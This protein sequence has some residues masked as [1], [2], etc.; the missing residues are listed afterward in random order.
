[1]FFLPNPVGLLSRASCLQ[2]NINIP[3][4]FIPPPRTSTNMRFDFRFLVSIC[5]LAPLAAANAFADE[6]P[7]AA[8]TFDSA[9]ERS[10]FELHG[11]VQFDVAGPRPTEFPDF[12]AKN[13]AVRLDGKGTYLAIADEGAHSR[14]DFANGDAIT[15]EAW[16]LCDAVK[17]TA[18]RY[19]V[20]KGRT[21]SAGF[22]RDNQNW[23]LR[24]VGH[25]EFA[26]ISF[27][28]ANPPGPGTAHWHRWDSKAEFSVMNGW[29]HVAVSYQFGEPESIRGWID[30]VPTDGIWSIGGATSEPPV[31]DDDA[32]WIGS[33]L[34][35]NPGSCFRGALDDIQIHRRA[36][37]DKQVAARFNRVGGPRIVVAMEP[38]MP[39]VGDIP[40]GKVMVTMAESLAAHDRWPNQHEGW[41]EETVSWLGD[42]FLLP[43]IPLR[44]DD[45]GIRTGWKSPVL[46][47]MSADVDLAAGEHQL[48]LRARA[49]G[50]LWIDGKLIASTEP[51]TKDPP[52]GEER[53]LPLP[54]PLQ[55]GMRLPSYRQQEVTGEV[56]VK[57]GAKQLSR[58]VLELVVG[59]KSLR[60][61][62]GEVSI[63]ILST[64]AKPPADSTTWAL[65]TP[66][67]ADRV[68]FTDAAIKPKLNAIEDAIA[69]LDDHTR[70][71]AASS[72]DEFW[73][74]R[75]EYAR[76]WVDKHPAAEVPVTKQ[77]ATHPIDA[78]LQADMERALEACPAGDL[79]AARHFHD[80]VLPILRDNCF[81]CHDGQAKGGLTISN[82]DALLAGG[83]SGSSAIVPGKPA[84]SE[85]LARVRETDID[86]RMPPTGGAL[87]TEEITTLE[88]WIKSGAEWPAAP[89]SA[90][91]VALSPIIDDAK[92]LRR[93][94]LDT[95]GIPPSDSDAKAFLADK[96]ADKEHAKNKRERLIDQLLADERC[97]DNEVSQ[98]LDML[99]ENPTL[100]NKSQGSTG[101]FRFFLHDALRDNKPLDRM[102]TELIMMRGGREEGGSAGFSMAAENDA[103]FAG[104]AH[105]VASAFLGVELQCARCHDAPF[106][107]VTQQDLFSLAAML[108]RK[109][110]TVPGTSRVPAAF[111]DSMQ[112]PSMIQVTLKAGEP[113]PPAW[114]FETVSGIA[115][116][117]TV[118]QLMQT[119][120][121]SRERLAT[122]LTAADNQRFPKVMVNR[123]WKRLM[124]VGLVEPIHDWEGRSASNP[125]LLDWLASE[126]VSHNFDRQHIVRLIVTSDAYQREATGQNSLAA[127]EQRFFNAPNRRRLS[128]EQ[129]VDSLYAV[130][131]VPMDIGELTFV[132]DGRRALSN[133]QT[134][135]H[136]SR[137]WMLARLNNERDRPSLA[138]PRAIVV[139]DVL[140]AF[141]WTG[142]RQMP[143]SDRN[144]D[145]NVL[146]P[147]ALAN[148][149]LSNTLSRAAH[150]SPLAQLAVDTKSPQE[151]VDSLFLS[152]LT[153][154]PN[155]GERRA[156]TEVLTEG[157]EDRL[158]PPSQI[159]V[160]EPPEPLPLVT[161][162]NHVRPNANTIQ[163]Q[164]ERRVRRGPPVDPRLK[165]KWREVYEDVVWSL[166]NHREFVWIP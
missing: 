50:R 3:P 60:A 145:P 61:E 133:R 77:P 97:A 111:F 127:S 44:Y 146:Q 166:I 163:Q 89:V 161:W 132:Y 119:P 9:E 79:A 29:H 70:R 22:A 49:L 109:P 42:S 125:D 83:D 144:T 24:V 113:V 134:L 128:A 160:V 6:A 71:T 157:F 43:R 114:P 8:W 30:G 162:F 93:I 10:A 126:L 16:V 96:Q 72:Q 131:S 153:R 1:M 51:I 139:T 90:A 100:L 2:C 26:A 56:S 46:L 18:T 53:I 63:S 121:D 136:P 74:K 39:E 59:G 112:R 25:G 105:I 92:F 73:N 152:I 116:G 140:E 75:H 23:S 91:D 41:P 101:P 87:P 130:T 156:F 95:I 13:K 94:F 84:E 150:G 138:L 143:I 137:A 154:H 7:V 65:L 62:T 31:E 104:K 155:D 12:S 102:V 81:R 64:D 164:L 103:P 5:L 78:F 115:D 47:R 66:R 33:S 99:G 107:D 34:G 86:I 69:E 129:V 68:P 123:I 48:L 17:S 80:K 37:T 124:G 57:P 118:D 19:L 27:L 36:L 21:N 76:T 11:D 98:W 55:P 40:A 147:G 106:H 4:E 141:G 52:N 67:A 35:G 38:E 28:F 88:N 165:T 20:S 158:V 82:R 149:V 110:A 142:S 159:A 32:V 151:L 120:D 54:V 58:V 14:F 148:G 108:Q 15:L 45:W 117:A 122:L 135:G 85:V